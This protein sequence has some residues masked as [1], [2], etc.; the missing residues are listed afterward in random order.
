LLNQFVDFLGELM[1]RLAAPTLGRAA[2]FAQSFGLIY[3]REPVLRVLVVEEFVGS[4]PLQFVMRA[5]CG[6]RDGIDQSDLDDGL[7]SWDC[8]ISSV[9]RVPILEKLLVAAQG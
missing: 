4:T 3:L 1:Q 7:K 9:R 2:Q 8:V 5:V 6:E